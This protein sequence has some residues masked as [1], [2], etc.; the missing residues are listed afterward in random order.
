MNN[1]LSYGTKIDWGHKTLP[2][3]YTKL[4]GLVVLL[5]MCGYLWKFQEHHVSIIYQAIVGA[6]AVAV[7][8]MLISRWG[9]D[10]KI[11]QCLFWFMLAQTVVQIVALFRS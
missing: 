8:I 3:K 7:T 1:P 10:D 5:L 4:Y 2:P 9:K 11:N 6:L